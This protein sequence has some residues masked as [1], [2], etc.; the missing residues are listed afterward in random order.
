MNGQALA[1]RDR[2]ACGQVAPPHS[3]Y[4]VTVDYRLAGPGRSR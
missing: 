2:I 3:L 1:A 4:L